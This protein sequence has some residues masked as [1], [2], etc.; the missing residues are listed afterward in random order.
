MT[1][2]WFVLSDEVGT[3]LGVYESALLDMAKERAEKIIQETACPVYLHH[4]VG[5]RPKV[6]NSIGMKNVKELQ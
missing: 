3:I 5:D 1:P 6:G 4:I 2:S